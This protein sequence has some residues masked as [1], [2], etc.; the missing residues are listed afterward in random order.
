[1]GKLPDEQ[2][3]EEAIR[4]KQ[5]AL[6]LLESPVWVESWETLD[7]LYIR[8]WRGST[9]VEERELWH[10]KVTALEEV[11]RLLGI[12]IERGEVAEMI[13]EQKQADQE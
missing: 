10:V 13:R 9:T 2:N 7:A 3:F 11:K 8:E 4:N 12:H 1:M 5:D 6:R